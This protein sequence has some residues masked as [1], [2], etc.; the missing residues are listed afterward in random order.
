MITV[1]RAL[2]A[3]LALLSVTALGG[4]ALLMIRPDGSLM[5]MSPGALALAKKSFNADS[6]NIR[7]IASMG[8]HALSL[9]YDTDESKEG[10]VAFREK[11]K[12]EFRKVANAK[13]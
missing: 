8:M 13:K 10:G 12:P 1:R 2:L 11:R 9:Y 4:G 5:G 7:G 6:D 3:L